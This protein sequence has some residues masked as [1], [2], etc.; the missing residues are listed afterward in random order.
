MEF[1]WS[2]GGEDVADGIIVGGVEEACKVIVVAV[3][4]IELFKVPGP[5]TS[6]AGIFRKRRV[7][8][9]A[10]SKEWKGVETS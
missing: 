2:G 5:T 8:A 6:G 1:S 10:W 4:T 3:W 7:T 9:C